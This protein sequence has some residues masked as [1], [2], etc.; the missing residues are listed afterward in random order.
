MYQS[1]TDFSIS[2]SLFLMF[3]APN[4]SSIK[5]KTV[6]AA[7]RRCHCAWHTVHSCKAQHFQMLRAVSFS[8]EVERL[9]LR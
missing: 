1:N 7:V 4:T 2:L 8:D 5:K 9:I 6:K 3:Q